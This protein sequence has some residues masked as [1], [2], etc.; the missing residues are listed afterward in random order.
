MKIFLYIVAGFIL[1]TVIDFLIALWIYYHY[2][3]KGD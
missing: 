1:L 3:K 2:K